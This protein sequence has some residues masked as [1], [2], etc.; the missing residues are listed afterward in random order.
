[1]SNRR[2]TTARR[3]RAAAPRATAVATL[4]IAAVHGRCPS[5]R[6]QPDGDKFARARVFAEAS[7]TRPRSPTIMLAAGCNGNSGQLVN[8]WNS[9]LLSQSSALHPTG[10]S[11]RLPPALVGPRRA[12]A[13]PLLPNNHLFHTR[14]NNIRGRASGSR[15]TRRNPADTAETSR[16]TA[17]RTSRGRRA[18]TRP[19]PGRPGRPSP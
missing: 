5:R 1:M 3:R 12:S 19:G 16:R 17:R 8:M 9:N 2:H 6:G 10:A 7:R 14:K 4:R 11:E 15:G 18:G 13:Y